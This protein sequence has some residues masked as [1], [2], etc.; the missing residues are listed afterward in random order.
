V[1]YLKTFLSFINEQSSNLVEFFST[2]IMDSLQESDKLGKYSTIFEFEH[3]DNIYF[4]LTVFARW[5]RDPVFSQDRYFKELRWEEQNFNNF[6][7]SINAIVNFNPGG[8]LIPNMLITILLDPTREPELYSKLNARLSGILH[9]E[10]N[11]LTQI[12]LNK[13]RVG[14]KPG[15]QSDRKEAQ[16]NYK[17]FLLPEEID[18]MVEDKVLQAK[19]EMRPVDEIMIEYLAPFLK[20]GFMT[21]SEMNLVLQHW[22]KL[23][24]EKSPNSNFS[25]RVNSIINQI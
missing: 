12:G 9:H 15:T 25:S 20:D 18:S 13:D 24:L 11:H 23:A 14:F 1:K 19:L 6:G 22:I 21:E 3:A 10:I 5:D 4:D 2:R 8:S 16:S 17:Y 7:Y